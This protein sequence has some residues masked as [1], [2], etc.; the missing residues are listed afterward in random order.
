MPSSS[1]FPSR[2]SIPSSVTDR[3]AWPSRQT[4]L[5]IAIAVGTAAVLGLVIWSWHSSQ[6]RQAGAAYAVAIARVQ[7][8]TRA[9]GQIPPEVRAA[10]VRDLE[11]TL[12]AYPSGSSSAQGAY[13]L[14]A[15]KYQDRQY[16][17]ARRAYELTAAKA[18]RGMLRTLARLGI[19]YTWEAERDFPK[20]V[21]AY[22]SAV[23]DLG[24][25]D[26]LYEEALVDLGRVQELAG[27][28]DDAVQTYR[29]LL[30][31]RPKSPR[32]DDLRTRLASLGVTP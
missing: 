20:A 23:G 10:A 12:Q 17:A 13:E 15:V 8:A 3:L 4:S 7:Q 19:G 26:P 5:I 1:W 9:A 14:A 29:R 16:S 30:K 27:R 31:D 18:S 21:G 25:S 28:K 11:A 22:Q 2:L 6:E 32:A 24:T